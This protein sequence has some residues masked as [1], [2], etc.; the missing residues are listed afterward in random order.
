MA[1][2]AKAMKEAKIRKKSGGDPKS[3]DDPP[4]TKNRTVNPMNPNMEMNTSMNTGGRGRGGL[5]RGMVRR[6][7]RPHA[8]GGTCRGA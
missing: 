5:E 7:G 6:E 2:K 1:M 4:Q 3:C 8:R